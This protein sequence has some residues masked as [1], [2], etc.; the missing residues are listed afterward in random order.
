MIALIT[1]ITQ[2]S[3]ALMYS[4]NPDQN[5]TPYQFSE[6]RQAIYNL[7]NPKKNLKDITC[8]LVDK[9]LA[10]AR[11]DVLQKTPWTLLTALMSDIQSVFTAYDANHL[12]QQQA[13]TR[14]VMLKINL[15]INQIQEENKSLEKTET[16]K[17]K[18]QADY[19]KLA[20]ALAEYA[21]L[22]KGTNSLLFDCLSPTLKL[23]TIPTTKETPVKTLSTE[24]LTWLQQHES[25]LYFDALQKLRVT[26]QGIPALYQA[27]KDESNNLINKIEANRIASEKPSCFFKNQPFDYKRQTINLKKTNTLLEHPLDTTTHEEYQKL[28]RSN[29]H[30]DTTG[31]MRSMLLFVTAIVT[32]ILAVGL[33]PPATTAAVIGVNVLAGSSLAVDGL[34]IANY[35]NV[36]RSQLTRTEA[37]MSNLFKAVKRTQEPAPQQ[38]EAHRSYAAWA[39]TR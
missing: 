29:A 34:V 30:D 17:K 26:N 32:I 12:A 23:Y 7:N 35:A 37:K 21:S 9:N 1:I 27:I 13:S 14:F 24:D 11:Q 31:I 4:R 16:A 18:Y 39:V 28:I 19:E 33:S 15:L 10:N 38:E 2:E 36:V 6:W 20:A 3:A 22:L 25:N 5:D 8:D